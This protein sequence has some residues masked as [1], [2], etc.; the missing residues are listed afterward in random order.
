MSP[1]G[2]SERANDC[3]SPDEEIVAYSAHNWRTLS[4][5]KLARTQRANV[6]VNKAIIFISI[7]M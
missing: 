5:R 1:S 7:K 3:G 2:P 6:S 4:L